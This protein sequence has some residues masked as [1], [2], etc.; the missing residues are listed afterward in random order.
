MALCRFQ[1]PDSMIEHKTTWFP[2]QWTWVSIGFKVLDHP[3]TS[4]LF[5]FFGSQLGFPTV[6]STFAPCQRVRAAFVQDLKLEQQ[7][8]PHLAN[9]Q[10][11]ADGSPGRPSMHLGYVC[12]M[13][14]NGFQFHEQWLYSPFLHVCSA[15]KISVSLN[16]DL[17]LRGH[18]KIIMMFNDFTLWI[19]MASNTL[20]DRTFF[21]RSKHLLRR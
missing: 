1:H 4:V 5:S 17:E 19:P 12:L 21:F 13:M 18:V 15:T 11:D 3:I 8:F 10:V 20:W 7:R 2:T 16:F 14:F 9:K 6:F